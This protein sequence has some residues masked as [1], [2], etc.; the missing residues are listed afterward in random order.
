MLRKGIAIAAL[1]LLPSLAK[2]QAANPWEITLG[3]NAAN[4]S[5]FDGFTAGV[6]GSIG[7]YFSETLEVALR[8]NVTYSDIG[9]DSALNGSTRVALDLHFPLGDKN[10]VVPYIGANIGYVYGDAVAE[11]FAAAPEAGL[12]LYVSPQTFVFIAAEYQFFFE[13]TDDADDAFE[14]GQFLYSLGIGFRF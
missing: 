11:G 8:Q 4:S 5:D 10:Q 1:C 13:D 14:D 2:A 3:G 7:Y 9:V 12:K 6:N